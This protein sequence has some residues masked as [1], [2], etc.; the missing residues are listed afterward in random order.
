MI[1]ASVRK[2]VLALSLEPGFRVLMATLEERKQ[3]ILKQR[4]FLATYSMSCL[5]CWV[6]LPLQTSPNS[7]PPMMASMVMYLGSCNTTLQCP[8]FIII[9]SYLTNSL[10]N[11]LTA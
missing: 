11:C 3:L 1:E 2:S 9:L 6:N 7:P 5:S 8:F 10:A 4:E